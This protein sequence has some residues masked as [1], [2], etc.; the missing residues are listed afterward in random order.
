[1]SFSV[2]I[3]I[4]YSITFVFLFFKYWTDKYLVLNFYRK[5]TTFNEDVPIS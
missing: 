5:T 4:L 3:P 2:T 1:M